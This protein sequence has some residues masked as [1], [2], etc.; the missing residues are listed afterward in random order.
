M[1][2]LNILIVHPDMTLANQPY[3]K[4]GKEHLP[5]FTSTEPLQKENMTPSSTEFNTLPDIDLQNRTNGTAYGTE[6]HAWAAKM[7]NTVWTLNDL[8]DAELSDHDKQNLIAFAQSSLYQ[9]CLSG[10]IHK[11]YPFYIET[12]KLNMNGIMDFVSIFEDHIIL[13]DFKT[14]AASLEEIRKRYCMQLNAYRK[15]LQVI[16]PNRPVSVY[17]WSFH[18][19]DKIEI[20]E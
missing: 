1:N 7:P 15:A 16:Y 12:A 20:E 11:E 17:A 6:M 9:E 14:D 5:H 10:E 8:K 3:T 2:I 18:N 13:I 19:C 4:P